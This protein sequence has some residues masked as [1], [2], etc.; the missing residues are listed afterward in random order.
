[1]TCVLRAAGIALLLVT[2]VL[3]GAQ[4]R[5]A[6]ACCGVE[7]LGEYAYYEELGWSVCADCNAADR[8]RGC[9]LPLAGAL[10][11]ED[12]YCAR[13]IG[14][15]ERCTSCGRPMLETFW[16]VEGVEG[17]FCPRCRTEAPECASCGAPT[18]DGRRVGERIFCRDCRAAWV[19][20]DDYHAIYREVTARA[21]DLLGL[22]IE[23]LP[24]LVIEQDGA[25]LAMRGLDAAPGADVC[26]LYLRDESGRSTIHLL[27][28][29][30]V[31]RT[32]AV[33]AHELAHAW[34][35]ENCSPHQGR[36]LR[37]GFAEW[38]AWKLLEG[39]PGSDAERD[40]IAGRTDEYGQGYRM[41]AGIE[42]THG[43]TGPVWYA[44]FAR[45]E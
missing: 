41:F 19:G 22:K 16:T 23:R 45:R 36:R 20:Q 40:V 9:T 1:M 18:R 39:V 17:R 34:Q 31:V 5:L 32:T 26:G 15:A 8:C 28:H 14:S 42:E 27:S 24:E 29:L 10:L 43:A 33:L 7:I 44:R 37:E 4:D 35:A 30:S 2:G 21:R 6:C 13:C 3:A 12:G 11:G 38:A 25:A